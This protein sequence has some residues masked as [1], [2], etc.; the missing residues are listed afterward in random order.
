VTLTERDNLI[1]E[2]ALEFGADYYYDIRNGTLG[3]TLYIEAPNKTEA[4]HIRKEAPGFW[5][6]LYVVVLYTSDPDFV[7]DS[8][9]DPKLK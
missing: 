9:Y 6:D 7:P 3:L 2:A 8:L 1:L 4:G 5:K